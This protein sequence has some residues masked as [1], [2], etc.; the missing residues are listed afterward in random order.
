MTGRTLDSADIRKSRKPLPPINLLAV[1]RWPLGGI[2]TYMRYV[3]SHL[4]SDYRITILATSTHEDEALKADARAINARLII[5][6]PGKRGGLARGIFEELL[7]QKPDIVQS[8]GYITGGH[9]YLGTLPFR[10]PHILTVHGVLEEKY[11]RNIAGRLKLLFLRHVLKNVDVLYTVGKDMMDH[12]HGAVP[13]LE[14]SKS[15]K[16]VI[17]NGIDLSELS[18]NFVDLRQELRIDGGIRL[19]GY[20]GRFMPEKGFE[21]L[22]EASSILKKDIG[23]CRDFKIVAIGSGDYIREYRRLVES[24]GLKDAFLFLPF[25]PGVSRLLPSFDAVAMPSIWEACPLVAMEALCTGTPLIA[26]DC[27]GLR[28]TVSGTPAIVFPSKNARALSE[29]LRKVIDDPPRET[30]RNFIGTARGM[31]DV[32]KTARNLDSLFREIRGRS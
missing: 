19:I 13:G 24:R 8:H 20:V 28:E 26:S 3:Y 12:L 9:V 1:A 2:R 27:M 5:H 10:R 23:L 29:A 22:V 21:Y 30:F 4:P 14:S 16:V 25:R 11:L 32:A 15:R 7:K 18:G 6:P 17:P 31:Y